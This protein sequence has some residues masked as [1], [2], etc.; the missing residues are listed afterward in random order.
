MHHCHGSAFIAYS[1]SKC[2]INLFRVQLYR[3]IVIQS[4]SVPNFT[5]IGVTN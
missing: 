1:V 3:N 4:F 2:D 5:N